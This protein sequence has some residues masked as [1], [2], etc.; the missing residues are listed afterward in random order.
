M[1]QNR[2]LEN[3]N[4]TVWKSKNNNFKTFRLLSLL[5]KLLIE[6]QL[7]LN[8]IR[9]NQAIEIHLSTETTKCLLFQTTTLRNLHIPFNGKA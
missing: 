6:V 7:S 1:F 3:Q 4:T 2:I 8:K 9:I 5:K